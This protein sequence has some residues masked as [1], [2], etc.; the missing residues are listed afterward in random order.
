MRMRDRLHLDRIGNHH[1]SHERRQHTGHRHA[2]A[3]RLDHDLV[4]RLQLFAKPLQPRSGHI[5]PTRVP[6]LSVF[7]NHHLAKRSVD[8][9]SNNPSHWFLLSAQ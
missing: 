1:P 5:D 6:K 4:G 2:V 8:V 9:H 7:P 3:S